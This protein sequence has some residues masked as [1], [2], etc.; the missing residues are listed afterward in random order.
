MPASPDLATAL[1][2]VRS[3]DDLSLVARLAGQRPRREPAAAAWQGPVG[4]RWIAVEAAGRPCGAIAR[5]MARRGERATELQCPMVLDP[6]R[7]R[8]ALSVS[9]PPFP[10]L[11][12]GLDQPDPVALRCLGLLAGA[13]PEPLA[14]AAHLARALDGQ[15]AGRRFFEAFRGSLVALRDALPRRAPQADRH[16]LALLDLT[17]ILF[18]YFV[19]AKGWLDGR[20]RFLAG[21]VDRVLAARGDLQRD[22]LHPLFFGTLNQP[23]S[24]RGA[25]ARRFGAVPFLN[26]GLFEPHALE[27]RWR[28]AFP[29]ALLRDAFDQVFERFHFTVSE[30]A[31]GGI[32]PD[33]LGRVF[34]GVMDPA[35]RLASGTFYTPAAVVSDLLEAG[36]EA[37]LTRRLGCGASEAGRRL[38]DPDTG[39]RAEVLSLRIL[40]PAAGSGAFLLG[41]F[42]LLQ[43]VTGDRR[44]HAGHEILRRNLFGVDLSPTAV[45]LAELRLWLALI[46]ADP[47]E[48]PGEVTPLP[49]LDSLVRSGDSLGELRHRARPSL[50]PRSV[51]LI[52]DRRAAL[53]VAVGPAKRAA[54]QALQ[55]AERDAAVEYLAEREAT[56]RARLRD[57]QAVRRSPTLFGEPRGLTRPERLALDACRADRAELYAARRRV[58]RDGSLPWFEYQTHFAEV[59]AAR[60]GFDLVA[61]NPPWVRAEQVPPATRAALAGR[62]RWWAGGGTRGYRHLPDLSVAFLERAFELAAPDGVVAMLLPAKLASAGY[63]AAAREA[64]ARD[65]T[66]YRIADLTRDPRATFEATVYPMALVA[67]NGRSAPRPPVRGTLRDRGGTVMPREV[68]VGPGPWVVGDESLRDA[69]GAARGGH[70]TIGSGFRA[71]LGV[72]TGYNAAF[73]D[74]VPAVEPELLRWAVRGRDVGPFVATP[75]QRLLWTHGPEGR[76]LP[77]LPPRAAAWI[78][79][80]RRELLARRDWSGGPEWE[81]FRTE[82]ATRPHRVV[83]ADLARRLEAV[84]LADPC[85]ASLVPLN[86]CYVV[87]ARSSAEAGRLAAWLNCTWIR[88]LAASAA[89]P[90]AGNCRRFVAR[91]VEGLP[92]PLSVLADRRLD[93]CVA[94]GRA[95]RLAQEDLDEA[96]SR[97]L[98]L[99]TRHRQAL[100]ASV[101]A[102]GNRRR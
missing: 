28:P 81:L 72:K 94:A 73:L 68:G 6:V 35:E 8:L 29:S 20:D 96:C 49:N 41:A 9:L 39:V 97:H 40:D 60:G 69:I 11:E 55:E 65:H 46:A 76:P 82:A 63:A 87:A 1:A 21:E 92:L 75:R 42:H 2:T 38:R 93:P 66:L 12:A 101:P 33:M 22:L 4:F 45:R 50:S 84:P 48:D 58:E 64:L 17:R 52:R 86:T 5:G 14:L 54:L 80:H 85:A 90:A 18:L 15:A 19:Q 77:A 7:R 78:G 3:L 56:L 16:A 62:F 13:P 57:L 98:G 88:A 70:P 47:A 71:A 10:V 61:G 53:L 23:P 95:G 74:P 89:D 83:W 25:L 31:L 99:E 26:G 67:G 27:R 30:G 44:V 43:A 79:A 32:A 24:R 59:F 102:P 34:E 37:L 100:A 36:I 91:V 51:A